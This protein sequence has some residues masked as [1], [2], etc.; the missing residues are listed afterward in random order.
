MKIRKQEFMIVNYE[1]LQKLIKQIYGK[2]L[3]IPVSMGWPNDSSHQVEI[4]KGP[5]GWDIEFKKWLK[6]GYDEEPN[7]LW[8]I[9]ND[10][11]AKRELPAGDYLIVVCW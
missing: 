7:A 8:G 11:C 10:L 2:E 9:L 6:T 5:S 1:D 3:N 4:N